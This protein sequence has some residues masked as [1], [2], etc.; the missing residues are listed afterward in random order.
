M[1]AYFNTPLY[2]LKFRELSRA[3]DSR[4]KGAACIDHFW[5][6]TLGDCKVDDFS[7]GTRVTSLNESSFISK[8]LSDSS[9]LIGTGSGLFNSKES[10]VDMNKLTLPISFN[11]SLKPNNSN[12]SGIIIWDNSLMVYV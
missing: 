9:G 6:I 3:E 8:K 4:S 2:L 1:Q 11:Q 10:E 12:N 7:T 5:S